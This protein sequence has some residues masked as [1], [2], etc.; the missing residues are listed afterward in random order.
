MKNR[1]FILVATLLSIA[2]PSTVHADTRTLQSVVSIVIGYFKTALGLIVSLSVVVFVWYVA[3][4]FLRSNDKHAEGAQYVMWALIGLFVML[5]MWGLVNVVSNTLNL[6]NTS[7]TS[8]NP[9]IT[10]PTTS[11]NSS[12]SSNSGPTV[13]NPTTPQSST[14]NFQPSGTNNTSPNNTVTSGNNDTQTNPTNQTT[15]TADANALRRYDINMNSGITSDNQEDMARAI[16]LA[17]K[18][19]VP[20][21]QNSKIQFTSTGGVPTSITIDGK[22]VPVNQSTYTPAELRSINAAQSM[23]NPAGQ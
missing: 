21:Y 9:A 11:N 12:N 20:V 7:P 1:V 2:Y 19:G 5:S 6:N 16:D 15:Q 22:T 10:I 8:F 14:V 4:Y 3:Q 17:T 13:F 18:S 23:S